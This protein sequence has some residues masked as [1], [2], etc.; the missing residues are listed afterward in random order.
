MIT[1]YIF[2]WFERENGFALKFN[3]HISNLKKKEKFDFLKNNLILQSTKIDNFFFFWT[4][5]R[6]DSSTW[7]WLNISKLLWL[8]KPFNC[9]C[10]T[11]FIGSSDEIFINSTPQPFPKIII[12]FWIFKYTTNFM[13]QE[14][15]LTCQ[16]LFQGQVT[17]YLKHT[18]FI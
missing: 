16:S 9:T 10:W 14:N 2:R 1:T 18:F 5:L 15:W 13:K 3:L 7:F 6:L 8:N 4:K 17:K 12:S 11:F